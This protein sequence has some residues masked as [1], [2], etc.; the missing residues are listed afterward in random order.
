VIAVLVAL[1][2]VPLLFTAWLLSRFNLV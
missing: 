1:A 2:V